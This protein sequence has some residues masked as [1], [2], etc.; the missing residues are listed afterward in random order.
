M[1]SFVSRVGLTAALFAV[2]PLP[3]PRPAR[4]QTYQITNLG[5][6]PG[7]IDSQANGINAGGQVTGASA[8][9]FVWSS[10]L[11]HDLGTLGG[12]FSAAN[13]I[14]DAGQVAGQAYLTGNAQAHAFLWQNGRMQDL[15]A[16]DS[17]NSTAL[18]ISGGGVVVGAVDVSSNVDQQ[19]WHACVF[20]GKRVL[21]LNT[22]IPANSGWVL[23]YATSINAAG[24]IAGDGYLNGQQRGF[25]LTPQ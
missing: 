8:H 24:Q 3:A 1:S 12:D 5:V 17:H 11:L 20:T 15:D 22:Q 16:H 23:K 14:N 9:T 13:A 2:P 25:L 21:D 18:S 10:G 4:A 7:Q 19:V 6:L